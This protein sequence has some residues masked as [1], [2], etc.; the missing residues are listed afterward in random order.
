[1]C[2]PAVKVREWPPAALCARSPRRSRHSHPHAE[3]SS[4]R[5]A[6]RATATASRSRASEQL[7]RWRIVPCVPA[8]VGEREQDDGALAAPVAPLTSARRALSRASCRSNQAVAQA[9]A[10]EQFVRSR[11]LSCAWLQP[12][13]ALRCA[14]DRPNRGLDWAADGP[15]N[16]TSVFLSVQ[17]SR[18]CARG[19]R[20][21]S[22][23]HR[24]RSKLSTTVE[25]A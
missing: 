18:P 12:A 2:A 11:L 15:V 3:P 7:A 1:M 19:G 21:S 25:R 5:A 23:W 14:C 13:A 22:R 9:R 17:I 16:E 6:A 10:D 4:T 20:H 8:A 24:T